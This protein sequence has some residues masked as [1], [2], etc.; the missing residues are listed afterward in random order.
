MHRLYMLG[1]LILISEFQIII[2]ITDDY[3]IVYIYILYTVE[4]YFNQDKV[5][6]IDI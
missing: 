2:N 3:F 1:L 6:I 4:S 5:L